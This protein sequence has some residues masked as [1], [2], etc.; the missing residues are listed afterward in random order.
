M[1]PAFSKIYTLGSRETTGLLDGEVEITEKLDGSA[2]RFGTINAELI[3]C[4]KSC[5]IYPGK[6]DKSFNKGIECIKRIYGEGFLEDGIVYYGEYLKE[7]KHNCLVYDRPPKGNIALYAVRFKEGFGNY[8]QIQYH[9]ERLG[10]EA[11][12][13]LFSGNYPLQKNGENSLIADL[14]ERTSSLGN[15][16]LEGV[17]IKNYKNNELQM[18]KYVSEKFK[19]VAQ[20]KKI[21]VPGES[22][23]DR[24]K[25]QFRTEA[26]W[27]KAIQHLRDANLLQGSTADI[28]PILKEINQDIEDEEKENITK[29]L[30]NEFG[31]DILKNASIGFPQWYKERLKNEAENMG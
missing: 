18:G 19:E 1:I 25:Q 21:K 28:G 3:I 29:W 15:S 30:W 11:V 4:S 14:M 20:S 9:A 27:V 7:N 24:F 26:R 17:V 2:I 6:A 8:T 5:Q 13:L 23:F 22:R 12:N 31:K 10:L 16:L